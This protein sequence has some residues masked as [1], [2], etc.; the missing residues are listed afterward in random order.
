MRATAATAR[1]A[2]AP[3]G[4]LGAVVFAFGVET[5]IARH[6]LDLTRQDNWEWRLTGRSA[7]RNSAGAGVLAFGSSLVKLGV[8]PRVLEAAVGMPAYNLGLCAGSPPTSFF[9]LR[10]ALESGAAPAYVIVEFHPLSLT[11]DPWHTAA[12][13]P[14]LISTRETLEL[15][16][17]ERDARFLGAM[18]VARLLPSFKDRFEIRARLCGALRGEVTSGRA[19]IL[20]LRHNIAKNRGALVVPRR[21]GAASHGPSAEE[22]ALRRGAWRPN[23]FNERYVE[24]FLSLAESRGARVFWIIPPVTRAL[25]ELRERNG[26]DTAFRA[27]ARRCAG[28]HRGVT[29]IDGT[30][31]GIAD[32]SFIDGEHLDRD[33][34][35]CWSTAIASVLRAEA[36]GECGPDRW[37]TVVA[38]TSGVLAEDVVDYAQSL[39]AVER[40]VGNRTTGERR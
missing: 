32:G 30:R 3:L 1:R 25:Q 34:A 9:L 20:A 24:S 37:V 26:T 31:S 7:A 16:C 40:L 22:V 33:G 10:R 12:F 8:I 13:W 38:P 18:T 15:A 5:L 4:M 39:R 29:V 11:R 35:A 36:R 19:G 2:A 6:T 14:D 21:Q 28:R 27:F 17:R 23:G